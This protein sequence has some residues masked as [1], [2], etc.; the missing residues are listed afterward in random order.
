M[1]FNLCTSSML[2]SRQL[3]SLALSACSRPPCELWRAAEGA[4]RLEDA[5]RLSVQAGVLYLRMGV[6]MTGP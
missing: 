6:L 5:D 2:H 1:L 3:M 4:K